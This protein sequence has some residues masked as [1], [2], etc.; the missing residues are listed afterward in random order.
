MSRIALLMLAGLLALTAQPASALCVADGEGGCSALRHDLA[1]DVRDDCADAAG[2]LCLASPEDADVSF[3]PSGGILNLS[4][5][6]SLGVPLDFEVLVT[7][8]F[9]DAT[10]SDGTAER[11]RAD[12]ILLLQAIQP[13]ETRVHELQLDG[14]ASALRLQALAADARH[15][16]LD[17]QVTPVMAMTGGAPDVD[18]AQDAS[19]DPAGDAGK[20]APYLG[21]VA[22]V[23][24]LAAF[25]GLRRFD[26]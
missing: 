17:A 11:V 2:G 8:R 5:T 1:I 20:D 16:E 13:G 21:I 4:V 23:G 3:V 10:S 12:R 15:A 25:A 9:D 19:D 26:E 14:N 6:N 22:L 7:A 24:V 18:P